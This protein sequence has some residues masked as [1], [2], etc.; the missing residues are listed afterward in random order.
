M[1]TTRLL[2][3]LVILSVYG[4]AP[5]QAATTWAYSH[6]YEKFGAGSMGAFEEQQ[7]SC[8]EQI[9]V[10]GDP[11]SVQPGSPPE[12]AFIECMNRGNWCT[13]AYNCNKPGA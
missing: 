4:C 6:W 2:C 9:G 10:A 8:L 13:Q 12:N 1:V 3:S 7:K 5:R 11:A